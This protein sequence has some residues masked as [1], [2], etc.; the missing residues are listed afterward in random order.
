MALGIITL[1]EN[2]AILDMYN[3]ITSA[4]DRN[5]FLFG[6][7]IDL[8]KILDTLNHSILLRKLQFYS[9]RG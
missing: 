7:F 8:S 2:H 4:I 6:I 9:I 3:R 5:E 1:L